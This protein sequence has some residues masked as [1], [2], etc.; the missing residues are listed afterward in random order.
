M[1]PHLTPRYFRGPHLCLFAVCLFAS[2]LPRTASAVEVTIPLNIDYL[3]LGAALKDQLYNGANGRAEL[4]AGYDK[5]QFLYATN[6]RFGRNDGVLK[7]ETNAELSLGLAVAGKCI[8]PITWSGIIE[9]ESQPYVG[10]DLAI[11]FHVTNINLYNSEH[12]RTILLRGFDLIK[13]SLIP[14]L[15]TFSFDLRAPLRQLEDL[16]RAAAVPDA[17]GRVDNALSTLRPMSAVVPEDRGLKLT[18][19]LSVPAI[20]IPTPAASAA[21]L[22][23]AEIAAWQTMLDNWDAFSVFAIK[24]LGGT[25]EDKQVRS[26]LFDLLLDSR[27][28]LV[29]ALAR[30][31]ASSGP[32]PIRVIFI[33]EWTRL[34]T[35]IQSAAQRGMLGNRALEFLSFVSAGDALFAIDQAAP[36]LGMRISEDDLRRLARIMAPQYQADP[37]AFSYDTDL[38][39]QQM[40]GVT[41]PL[42]TPGP[43]EAPSSATG[44]TP[45]SSGTPGILP[46]PSPVISRPGIPTSSPTPKSSATAIP[47]AASSPA[48]MLR[49]QEWLFVTA[50]A[51]A[52]EDPLAAQIVSLGAVLRRVVVEGDNAS[53]YT[54][55]VENLL[56]LTA[57]RELVDKGLEPRYRQNYL[58]VVKSTAWQESCWRQF[59][60][61]HGRV[62][63]LE[64]PTADVGLMQVN[65]HVW[66]GFYSIP[67]LEWDI[68]YNAGAGAEILIRLMTGVAADASSERGDP[69][70]EVARSTYAAYNG[71]PDAH[72]RWRRA[73]EPAQARDIDQSFLVKFR[74][75]AARQQFDI[76][77]CAANWDRTHQQ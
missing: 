36:A 26:E 12:K 77:T 34:R 18:L 41:E 32:D 65:K 2:L 17:A 28:R 72:N 51:D 61:V 10:A 53:S 13:H 29:A 75:I 55:S 66:R 8:T 14:R 49:I 70:A 74:A 47:S 62:R 25:V 69:L 7:L 37:I 9:A 60:R 24:Q 1:T 63:F 48:A 40:F 5:C 42:E 11:K 4:W 3:T 19:E 33:D 76:M 59:V 30:P 52:A 22:S 68:V 27:Y 38:A 71:G 45:G 15:E 64:S 57:Q 46:T 50:D 43:L 31:E 6:P 23:P 56:T 16:V 73:D 67:R 39:L 20:A 44:P 58:I 21:P 54:R 35:I